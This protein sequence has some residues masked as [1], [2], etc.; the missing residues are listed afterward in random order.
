MIVL[1]DFPNPD[2]IKKIRMFR[3]SGKR[4]YATVVCPYIKNAMNNAKKIQK[5]LLKQKIRIL[6]FHDFSRLLKKN[7]P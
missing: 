6:K 1:S 3:L 2:I 7:I 4:D 5:T